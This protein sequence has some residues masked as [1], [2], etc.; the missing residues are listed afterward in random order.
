VERQDGDDERERERDERDDGCAHVGQEEDK[1]EHN[2]D[3]ALE[4]RLLYIIYRA[5]DEA[6]LTED[7]GGDVYV[8][9]QILLQ[10]GKCCLQLLGKL[11]GA[12]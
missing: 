3:T 12:C 6:V 11:D 5:A 8:G 10:V 9:G 2:E 1:D 7:I 4:E